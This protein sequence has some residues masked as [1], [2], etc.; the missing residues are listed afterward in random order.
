MNTT[1]IEKSAG[2]GI[3]KIELARNLRLAIERESDATEKALAEQ[4][5]DIERIFGTQWEW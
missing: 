4:L 2:R 3:R 1:F 5:E